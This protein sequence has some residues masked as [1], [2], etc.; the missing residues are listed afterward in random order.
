MTQKSISYVF[1]QEK[2]KHISAKKTY[3]SILKATLGITAKH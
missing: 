2:S 1:T 3:M